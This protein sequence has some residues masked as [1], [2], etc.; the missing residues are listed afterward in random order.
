MHDD[1]APS[2]A[3]I[4]DGISLNV[5]HVGVAKAQ[6]S[7]PSL[8]G[9]DDSRGNCILEGKRAADSDHK[10]P[11]SQVWWTAQQQYGKLGLQV[12]NTEGQHV[13]ITGGQSYWEKRLIHEALQN[14]TNGYLDQYI[15]TNT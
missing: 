15:E 8:S 10:L 9:A 11:W 4:D 13:H 12:R 7:A 1:N 3:Y 5:V 14:K 6:L 2:F